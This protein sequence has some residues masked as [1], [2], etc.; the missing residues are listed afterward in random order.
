[1]LYKDKDL[2][3]AIVR[4]RL[5][6]KFEVVEVK[7][8]SLFDL[9]SVSSNITWRSKLSSNKEV[10]ARCLDLIFSEVERI[11]KGRLV[12]YFLCTPQR[13][14]ANDD[15]KITAFLNVQNDDDD[16]PITSEWVMSNFPSM[17]PQYSARQHPECSSLVWQTR[18]NRFVLYYGFD[19]F[20]TELKTRGEVRRLVKALGVDIPLNNPPNPD[21][22]RFDVL[23][24]N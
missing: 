3:C 8:N 22:T 12:H 7:E 16:E 19:F 13:D 1:M 2:F 17:G 21:D 14:S 20:E 5:Y 6:K 23:E 15:I 10:M 24:I 9:P 4:D 11:T 18:F